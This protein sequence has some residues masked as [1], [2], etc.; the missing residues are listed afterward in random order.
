MTTDLNK[1][2]GPVFDFG[3]KEME[4]HNWDLNVNP[5]KLLAASMRANKNMFALTAL[6]ASNK[7][8]SEEAEDDLRGTFSD[9]P[10]VFRAGF[11]E[12]CSSGTVR[13]RPPIRRKP[14]RAQCQRNLLSLEMATKEK[15]KERREGKQEVGS[16]KRKKTNIG[17]EEDSTSKAQCLKV[18]PME[19][20]P[21]S[22]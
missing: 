7:G 14:P 22:Q 4:R 8:S 1:G 2:K 13:K 10:T 21:S 15:N 18:I 5:N 17:A 20:F 3:D 9:Y 19:G 6:M 12:P 11:L 16:R